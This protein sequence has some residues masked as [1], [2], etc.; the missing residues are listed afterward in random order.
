MRRRVD[1]PSV[2][3]GV[4]ISVTNEATGS[5]LKAESAADGVYLAPQLIPGDYT[6]SAQAAGF[7]RTEVQGVKV[8]VGTAV[9]Q[10]LTL[11]VG[12]IT[13]SVEVREKSFLVET[14]SGRVA[15]A[16]DVAHV[17]EMPLSNRDVFALV[18]LVPGAFQIG[19]AISIGGGDGRWSQQHPRRPG[20][21]EHRAGPAG[22]LDGG[23]QGLGQQPLGGV[24]PHLGRIDHDFT[25]NTKVYG[26]YMLTQPDKDLT[27][28]S[29]G[30]GPAD[31]D[32]ITVTLRRW[33]IS[34]PGTDGTFS[35]QASQRLVV[36]QN[37]GTFRLSPV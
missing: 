24:R 21:A 28:Y 30:Y 4:I 37:W 34:K 8:D 20:G 17:L 3:P 25:P 2:V 36:P 11:E 19:G 7:K 23:V 18:N 27:G 12:D 29:R 33:R 9:T 15:H 1:T 16:V 6:V 26:R 35:L 13:Q 31:P 14:T 5:G 10:D 32:G 22:G